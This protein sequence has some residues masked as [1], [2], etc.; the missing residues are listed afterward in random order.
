MTNE[1][2]TITKEDI[3][4]AIQGSWSGYA[5]LKNGTPFSIEGHS[6]KIADFVESVVIRSGAETKAD[7]LNVLVE[8]AERVGSTN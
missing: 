5:M 8:L 7:I 2:I 3:P 6:D 4:I 1:L